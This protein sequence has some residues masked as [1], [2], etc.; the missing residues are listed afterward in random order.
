MIVTLSVS[1]PPTFDLVYQRETR[2][3][4][5]QMDVT[6]VVNRRFDSL[7][8]SDKAA[9]KKNTRSRQ[10]CGESLKMT[11]RFSSLSPLCECDRDMIKIT[12]ITVFFFVFLFSSLQTSWRHAHRQNNESGN[13]GIPERK[14]WCHANRHTQLVYFL[15]RR[16]KN[17]MFW[18]QRPLRLI[19]FISDKP[20]RMAG[21]GSK[22]DRKW[23]GQEV[24]K[25]CF[26]RKCL[27]KY[28]REQ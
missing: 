12:I 8:V 9:K 11:Q 2:T 17:G 6:K 20:F 21:C 1:R 3:E 13:G 28:I 4:S 18:W 24:E 14:R 7:F 19:T 15:V 22:N 5:V 16:V 23:V 26:L 25:L 10:R 27:E